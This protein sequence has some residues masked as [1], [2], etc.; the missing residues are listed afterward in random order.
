MTQV[1]MRDHTFV[2]GFLGGQ[3]RKRNLINCIILREKK[4]DF[5]TKQ[6]FPGP[7]ILQDFLPLHS[8]RE[9]FMWEVVSLTASEAPISQALCS[10][11]SL[12]HF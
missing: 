1:Q 8:R 5:Q 3:S 6:V 2:S 11:D 9:A 10:E 7:L 12:K 4:H